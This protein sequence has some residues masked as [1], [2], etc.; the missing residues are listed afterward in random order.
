M[1]KVGK[2]SCGANES[3]QWALGLIMAARRESLE[4]FIC[5]R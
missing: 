1:I 5:R 4:E 3:R 2:P